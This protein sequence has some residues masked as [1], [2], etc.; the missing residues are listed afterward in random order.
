MLY[1]SCF[2]D[3]WMPLVTMNKPFELFLTL[4]KSEMLLTGLHVPP[5]LVVCTY[6]LS[7]WSARTPCPSGLHVPPVLVVCTYPLSWWSARTPCP[8]GLYVCVCPGIPL[9]IEIVC[10]PYTVQS[11]GN[12]GGPAWTT[13]EDYHNNQHTRDVC[14]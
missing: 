9:L 6:P 12:T 1:S 5:V 2:V 3:M 13:V 4:I 8:G 10:S 11:E 7:W 14:T